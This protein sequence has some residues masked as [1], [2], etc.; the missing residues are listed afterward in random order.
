MPSPTL[1][2]VPDLKRKIPGD[3]VHGSVLVQQV[4]N[5]MMLDG[6]KSVAEKIVYDALSYIEERTGSEEEETGRPRSRERAGA[7]GHQQ[8]DARRQEERGREDRVRCPL[9]H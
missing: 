3:P 7:A 8:D 4:I 1:R 2:S 6:K 5:K 9:L